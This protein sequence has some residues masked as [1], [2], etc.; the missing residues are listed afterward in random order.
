[1]NCLASPLSHS[2]RTWNRDVERFSIATPRRK[3]KNSLGTFAPQ[4]KP[5]FLFEDVCLP[6][7]RLVRV[8][9]VLGLASV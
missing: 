4:V 6:H 8:L 3:K 5:L 9:K 2:W 7:Y 1:M